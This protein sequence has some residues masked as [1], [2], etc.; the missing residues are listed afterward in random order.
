MSPREV[1][2]DE[3]TV[4]VENESYRWS[5][6]ILSFGVL[7]LAAYRAFARHDDVL[8]LILLVVASGI[9]STAYQAWRRTLYNRWVAMI[10]VSVTVAGLLALA[11]RIARRSP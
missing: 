9:A 4:A 1:E 8:D 11:I 7:A 10:A 5:Y 2:R 6:H 3:R